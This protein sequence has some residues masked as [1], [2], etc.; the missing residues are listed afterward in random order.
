MTEGLNLRH[1][2]K[3]GKREMQVHH[4]LQHLNDRARQLA[5]GAPARRGAR[6]R[7]AG[8]LQQL[9]PDAAEAGL[10]E[11]APVLDLRPS[12]DA[13]EAEPAWREGYEAAE[14]SG[15]HCIVHPA[16]PEIRRLKLLA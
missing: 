6:G 8:G 4:E 13:R 12:H 11:G 1:E 9:P 15:V 5:H 7:G 2:S 3:H 10:A 14:T 16:S